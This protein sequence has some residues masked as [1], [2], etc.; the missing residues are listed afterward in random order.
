MHIEI[1]CHFVRDFLELHK[2]QLEDCNVMIVGVQP[3]FDA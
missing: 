2:V 3:G 1:R